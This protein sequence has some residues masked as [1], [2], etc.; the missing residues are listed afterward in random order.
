HH[1]ENSTADDEDVLEEEN[2]VR[3]KLT[4][5]V[6]DANVAVQVHGIVKTYPGTFS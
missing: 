6:V 4:Q 2:A 3:Q 5:G 1:E